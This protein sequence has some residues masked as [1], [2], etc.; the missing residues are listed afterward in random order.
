MPKKPPSIEERLEQI[1]EALEE[2]PGLVLADAVIWASRESHKGIVV[3]RGGAT[4]K[5]VG[6]AARLELEKIFGR[7]FYL[8]THVKL[9]RDWAD[10]ERA[11]QQ[12]GFDHRR[13]ALK[14]KGL[15]VR[16]TDQ[17]GKVVNELL[18]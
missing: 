14:Y 10:S 15:D 3:G 11:L 12:F 9:K 6:T 4:L 5:R 16:L 13:L 2:K 7:K 8:E 17:G 1:Q 18:A